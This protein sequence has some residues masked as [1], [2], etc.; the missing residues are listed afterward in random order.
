HDLNRPI[1][2]DEIEEVIKRLPTKKS[3]G[4]DGYTAEFYKTFKEELIPILFKLFQEIEKEGVLPNSF[5]E[6]NITLIP[7][8]NKDTSKKEKYRPISLMNLDAKILNKILANRIQRHIKKIVHHDQVGFI[9]G[10][11]GWFNIRKSINV[12]HHINRL[13]D[14]NHM[15]ISIDA[16]KAFDKV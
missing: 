4:P 16:E 3:P 7:K 6:A 12:I 11:Q 8:P 10:M 13:K 9:P 1:S 5:Y 15:I 2:M 14:K